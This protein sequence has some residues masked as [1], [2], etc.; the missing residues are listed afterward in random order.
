MSNIAGAFAQPQF[1]GPNLA[2]AV[3]GGL[4]G[5]TT[6]DSMGQDPLL[7]AGI[8]AVTPGLTSGIGAMANKFD[9][10]LLKKVG[11]AALDWVDKAAERVVSHGSNKLK[12]IQQLRGEP[13]MMGLGDAFDDVKY[14]LINKLKPGITEDYGQVADRLAVQRVGANRTLAAEE[15]AMN[16]RNQEIGRVR[17]LNDSIEQMNESYLAPRAQAMEG[18]SSVPKPGS[19]SWQMKARPLEPVPPELPVQQSTTAEANAAQNLEQ[20]MAPGLNKNI[21]RDTR[22][23]F[24]TTVKGIIANNVIDSGFRR[25]ALATLK[26]AQTVAQK[27]LKNIDIDMNMAPFQKQ[28]VM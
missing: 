11:P 22:S 1:S 14:Q 28:T 5:A 2:K 3:M 16:A 25:G 8:G 24:A 17:E 12:T 6:A 4:Q 13:S 9:E 20:I 21:S 18:S 10:F 27:A 19:T 23:G 7:G 26:T 15:G